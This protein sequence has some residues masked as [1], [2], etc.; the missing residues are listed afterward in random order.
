MK[1][2]LG[3]VFACV[4]LAFATASA[5]DFDGELRKLLS[6]LQAMSHG[7]PEPSEWQAVMSQLDVVRAQAQQEGDVDAVVQALAIKAL[8]LSDVRGDIPAALAVLEQAKKDY[9]QR[10][11]PSVKRLYV[12]QA[13]LYSRQGNAEAVNKV[14]AEFRENPNFDPHD[15]SVF[16]GEGRNTPMTIV[17]PTARGADS[18]SIT[19]MEQA[20][21]RARFAPGNLFPA[22]SIND[23]QG[24]L[25]QLADYRGKV[26]LLDFWMPGWTPW[27]RDLEYMTSVYRRYKPVGMEVIG[28]AL[29]NAAAAQGFATQKQLPWKQVY[30]ETSLARQL[31]IF[32]EATNFLLDKNGMIIGRNLRGAELAAAVQRALNAQ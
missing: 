25:V 13:D 24:G 18:I 11:L 15:Y 26:V 28:I 27:E 23:G 22:F 3:L 31:G 32:G 7:S 14:I 9:G 21:E 16:I 30:G 2:I 20:R 8:V 17:R 1:R 10:K 12:Q 6:K 4:L 5:S 19:A 29:G